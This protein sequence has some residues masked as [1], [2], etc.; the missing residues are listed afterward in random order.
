M[1]DKDYCPICKANLRYAHFA[2]EGVYESHYYCP[3]P[4]ILDIHSTAIYHFKSI[5]RDGRPYYETLVFFP[6]EVESYEDVSSISRY[7]MKGS[8]FIVELPYL[9]LPWDQPDKVLQKLKTYIV[10]S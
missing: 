7:D 3:Q 4:P 1:W 6:Y 10:M 2:E 8:H 9:D 5:R